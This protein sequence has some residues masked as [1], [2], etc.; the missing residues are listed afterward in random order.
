MDFVDMLG[1]DGEDNPGGITTQV[2][3]APERDFAKPGGLKGVK[4]TAGVGDSV[5]IDGTHNFEAG[6]GFIE[7]Y[8]TDDSAEFKVTTVGEADGY[9][10]KIEGEFFYP[11]TKKQA[12]EFAR[13]AK[14]LKW[15]FITQTPDGIKHQ[16]GTK[17]LGVTIVGDFTTG[18]LSGGRRG[19]LFK[20][21]GYQASPLFYEGDI[22][23]KRDGGVA[24]EAPV[25][26]G[27]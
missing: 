9:G 2:F 22:L 6:K 25:E 26:G 8:A 20:V 12:I 24:P 1:P 14:N 4:K 16:W 3:L 15:I 21:T 13:W 19:Y 23:L 10:G 5:T 27:A 18:K 7:G 17:G 11:G